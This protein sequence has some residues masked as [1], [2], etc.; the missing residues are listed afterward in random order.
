[1]RFTPIAAEMRR[2]LALH[3]IRAE[4][5]YSGDESERIGLLDVLPASATKFHVVEF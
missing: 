1:V 2:L 4:L 5:I 3:A